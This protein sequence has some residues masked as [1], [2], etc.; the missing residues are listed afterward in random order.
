MT[1][2]QKATRTPGDTCEAR[3]A[4]PRA[5]WRGWLALAVLMQP[6]LVVS[7]DNT[8]L[9]FAVPQLSTA[10]APTAAQLLWIVDIYPLVL[11]GL[12]LTMGALGDRVGRRRLLMIGTAGFG[13]ISVAAAFAPDAAFLVGARTLL[14]FFGAM[15]MP[16]TLSLLR[17]IFLDPDQR[18]LAVAIWASGFAG[19]TAVG[20]VAGGWLLE[21]FWWGAIFL[22]AVPPALVL[23]GAAPFLV[24]ES[25]DS[26]AGRIDLTSVALSIGA[27]LP[28]AYAV[29][30]TATVGA[31]LGGLAALVVAAACGALF[32]RRQLRAD[33]PLL[34]L[35]LF[36]RPLF[37]VAVGANFLSVFAFAG[38]I[39]FASQ[40][41]QF[42][43][44]RSPLGA[45]AALV[46][47]VVA[48]VLFSLLAV[49][50]AK[51]WAVR[52]LI[53]AGLL[54][55]ATGF[56]LGTLL[57]VDTSGWLMVVVFGLVGAGSG[58]A[59]TLTNDAILTSAPPHRA[60]AAAGI[61]ETAY[62]L[63][64]AFGVAILGSVLAW[65]YRTGLDLPAGVRGADAAEARETIGSAL[66]VAEAL[67]EATGRAVADA[68]RVAF[69]S[70]VVVTCAI[71]ALL[72]IVAAVGVGVVL[73]RDAR[74][75]AATTTASTVS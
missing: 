54:T 19:G 32:V 4:A 67:P 49:Q 48:S 58:L 12:L 64:A 20:P 18:R 7:I 50:F 10:L 27:M 47:G 24:P 14:G 36:T 55:S 41:L 37:A 56:A 28:F 43:E 33:D 73:G 66:S 34:D 70:G 60:G 35:R 6:V 72:L 53:V 44:V 52:F 62:E 2:P 9:A 11:A 57:G 17:N 71:G 5:G 16:S 1:T 23:L 61:S 40:Q 51:L 13:A 42:V 38:L 39:F 26:A 25:R 63:G 21:H 68:A 22:I 15:L 3:E 59:E 75:A 31:D 30:H 45:A 46:P 65:R 29:K 8:A 74:N 69:E